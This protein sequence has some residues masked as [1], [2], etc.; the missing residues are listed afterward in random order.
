MPMTF[1]LMVFED[2]Q[3]STKAF[4]GSCGHETH[5]AKEYQAQCSQLAASAV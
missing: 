1:V 4:R 2:M 3:C 5:R